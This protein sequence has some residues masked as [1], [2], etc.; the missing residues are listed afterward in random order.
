MVYHHL[1]FTGDSFVVVVVVKSAIFLF[2]HTL[3]SD[4]S[5]ILLL[6][7]I[8]RRALAGACARR[9]LALRLPPRA[10]KGVVSSSSSSSFTSFSRKD[11]GGDDSKT[12]YFSTTTLKDNLIKADFRYAAAL[13]RQR[14][15][16]TYL[17]TCA[18]DASKRAVP[19]ALRALNCETAIIDVVHNHFGENTSAA[20][21]KLKW[22]HDRI[23]ETVRP[24]APDVQLDHPIARCVRA[25]LASRS[26][27]K[28]EAEVSSS[29]DD[30][31]TTLTT[32]TTGWSSTRR[33]VQ[34]LKRAIEA[35]MEDVAK[36]SRVFDS[37]SE[38]ERFAKETHGHF[39]L[40]TLDAENV[41]ST[42]SD[43]VA[44]HVGTAIGLTNSLRGAKIHARNRKTYFPMDVLATENLSAE[45]V[46][47]GGIG[48]ER[49]KNAAHK[50]ASA[51]V[52]HIAAARRIY[53]ENKL[54]EKY[55]HMAKLLLQATTA[56]RWLEKLE[57]YDFDVFREELQRTPR[58]MTQARV[59]LSAWKNQ[60]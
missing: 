40:V 21:M 7:I 19:L 28:W 33:W 20:L 5:Q 42:A 44:S 4:T 34:W 56:E 14:D 46:Y 41:R 47:D 12:E 58:L 37:M 2:P 16:E 11:N 59:F 15:Y 55:P 30:V 53:I 1:A 3:Y 54:V 29:N 31:G 9:R 60:F 8:M 45:T 50:V 23:D 13:L 22:W 51:A 32:T 18:V 38:L 52:G 57:K 48:D 36:G 10:Q 35:R 43:H 27:S 17:C 25:A 26:H 39:L 24:S 49:V 6:L